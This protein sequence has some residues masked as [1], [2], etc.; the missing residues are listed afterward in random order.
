MLARLGVD[1]WGEA[2]GL[3]SLPEGAARKRLGALIAQFTDVPAFG[4]TRSIAVSRLLAVL[5]RSEKVAPAN[6]LLLSAGPR[7]K[8]IYWLVAIGYW[9]AYVGLYGQ[10]N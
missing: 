9:L 8:L 3:A 1:P 6:H 2:A 4:A 7:A 5:P 10:G